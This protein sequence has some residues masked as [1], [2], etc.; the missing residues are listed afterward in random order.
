MK[1]GTSGRTYRVTLMEHSP[2]RRAD[3][4]TKLALSLCASLAVM[5]P[6]EHLAAFMVIYAALLLW[7]RLLPEAA[8]Q[9]WRLKWV[10]IPL[11]LFD[12]L[13]IDP[14]LATV[15]TLRII[16]LAGAFALFVGTTTPGELRLALEWLRVPYRYAFSVS[17][18]FQSVGLLD[19]EW[20]AIYEAQRA[21]GAWSFEWSGWRKFV[22]QI[23]DLVAL[24]VPAIVLTTKRAWA[25]T[26]AAY[27]RGFDSPHRRPFRQL[28]MNRLD[29]LL[30]IGTVIVSTT[31]ILWK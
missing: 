19:D 1:L 30:L 29:W 5:L 17:L 9:V 6:L 16:L 7:A 28:V 27:A 20:R 11:F 24:T 12:W 8:R 22:E 25:M 10:L 21:R 26:E 31:L 13:V 14:Y 4:R 15:V 18:A 23:R 2:L 3:P